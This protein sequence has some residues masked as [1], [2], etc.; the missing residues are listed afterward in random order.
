MWSA[1]IEAWLRSDRPL[2]SCV[3]EAWGVT[4]TVQTR[5]AVHRGHILPVWPA[6]SRLDTGEAT[7]FVEWARPRMHE[8]AYSRSRTYRELIALGLVE[9]GTPTSAFAD[10]PDDVQAA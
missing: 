8:A 5:T 6:A 2:G 3:P 10:L 7:A 4:T 1:L 9:S